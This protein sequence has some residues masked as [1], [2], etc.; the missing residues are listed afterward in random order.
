[1]RQLSSLENRR[2]RAPLVALTLSPQAGSRPSCGPS[3]RPRTW[4]PLPEVVLVGPG[5]IL[6]QQGEVPV[7]TR[8]AQPV[9]F[10]QHHRLVRLNPCH[11]RV[12]VVSHP[13]GSNGGAVPPRVSDPEKGLPRRDLKAP[14][15]TDTRRQPRLL[16][17]CCPNL[18][19]DPH[20][21]HSF[22]PP[23]AISVACLGCR[24]TAS[25]TT[26]GTDRP[27]GEDTDSVNS[28]L[29][30]E[31]DT[32]RRDPLVHCPK[33]PDVLHGDGV[34]AVEPE[35]SGNGTRTCCTK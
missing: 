12:Q 22:L 30:L 1:M 16:H 13:P 6:A 10:G 15:G 8:G 32:A 23:R 33:P 5:W 17:R 28:Q 2:A 19:A 11:T 20:P 34:R 24:R 9:P 18:S 26:A 27:G 25:M 14:V 29:A 3:P 31:K 7:R 21:R 4:H 35:R